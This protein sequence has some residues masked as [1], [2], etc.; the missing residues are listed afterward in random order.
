MFRLSI[1][2][3]YCQSML[4]ILWYKMAGC[5]SCFIIPLILFLFHRFIQP[6]ILKFWNPW[7]TNPK[8]GEKAALECLRSGKCER[9][10]TVEDS[11]V[12]D[13]KSEKENETESINSNGDSENG[14]TCRLRTWNFAMAKFLTKYNFIPLFCKYILWM[15][16]SLIVH[17]NYS[18]IL[19]ISSM[20]IHHLLIISDILNIE[21]I[22]LFYQLQ[23][24]MSQF[25]TYCGE[26]I[27]SN[28]ANNYII[29]ALIW[30]L[31]LFWW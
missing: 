29:Q 19:L 18:F 27:D 10:T 31:K 17:L 21:S 26:Y 25:I 12:V 20:R 11:K 5:V 28:I 7:D 22:K 9:K 24:F 30:G 15:S 16:S 6:L 2:Y 14:S 1:L 3:G 23:E 8:E 13:S 4:S